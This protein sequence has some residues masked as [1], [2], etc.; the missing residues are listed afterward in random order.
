MKTFLKTAVVAVLA[1]VA[2]VAAQA[3]TLRTIP[4]DSV[5]VGTNSPSGN[6]VVVLR[7]TASG[8]LLKIGAVSTGGRGSGTGEANPSDPLGSQGSLLLSDDGQWLF[9][10]NAASNQVSAFRVRN[11]IPFLTSVVDSGGAYPNSITARGDT[12]YVL[13]AGGEGRVVGFKLSP[14]GRLN[15]ITGSTRVLAAPSDQ[16][17]KQPNIINAPSQVKFSPDGNFLVVTDKNVSQPPGTVQVFKVGTDGSLAASPVVN[18]SPDWAPFGFTFDRNGHMLVTDAV[19]GGMSSYDI[20]D[21]GTLAPISSL[22]LSG[23][24]EP[25]WIDISRNFAFVSNTATDDV[26]LFRVALNGEMT[27]VNASAG[28]IGA[29]STPIDVTVSGDERWLHALSGKNG[30]VRTFR[31]DP[32]SGALTLTDEIKLFDPLLGPAGIAAE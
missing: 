7:R 4:G 8:R 25:C 19:L 27:L 31:I 30:V 17:N 23:R 20:K 14:F 10:V 18:A 13:N 24:G 2:G 16:V 21:D 15:R 1:S 22:V 28:Q 26:S 12:V 3:G 6:Q 9:A 11:G 29:A 5:F 32:A